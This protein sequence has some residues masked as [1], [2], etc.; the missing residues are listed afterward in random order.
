MA[1]EGAAAGE[2]RR[3]SEASSPAPAGAMAESTSMGEERRRRSSGSKVERAISMA[4]FESSEKGLWA[5][6]VEFLRGPRDYLCG[7]H[8]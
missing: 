1:G 7:D 5:L 3:A 4:A 2:G 8:G 6:G